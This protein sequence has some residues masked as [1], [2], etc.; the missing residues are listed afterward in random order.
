MSVQ[1]AV[2]KRYRP[3]PDMLKVFEEAIRSGSGHDPRK[4]CEKTGVEYKDWKNWIQR[5]GFSEWWNKEWDKAL[6]KMKP[7]LE[8]IGMEK[9]E[10][11]FRYWK[12]MI[13]RLDGKGDG[14]ARI[15]LGIPRPRKNEGGKRVIEGEVIN[16]SV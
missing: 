13:E 15:Y 16:G 10:E 12:V 1:I 14:G 5:V 3:E 6:Q 11:D 2:Q 8:K 7:R 9:A 4:W